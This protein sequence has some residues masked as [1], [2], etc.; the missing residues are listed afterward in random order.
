MS[1]CT[2]VG[3]FKRASVPALVFGK[4]MTSRIEDALQRIAII[5][6]KPGHLCEA[7]LISLLPNP[8]IVLH[9]PSAIPPWGGAPH[10]KAWSKWLNDAFSCSSSCSCISASK[11][12]YTVCRWGCWQVSP[13]TLLKVC[14]LA[15]LR[16]EFG[17]NHPQFRRRLI[18]GHSVGPVPGR[19]KSRGMEGEPHECPCDVSNYGCIAMRANS[20]F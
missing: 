8:T 16:H 7:V 19:N 20:H 17:Q 15:S 14:I 10:L 5:R 6:S 11:L 2:G 4:A 12:D 3:L 1:L 13:V 9:L 18:Q